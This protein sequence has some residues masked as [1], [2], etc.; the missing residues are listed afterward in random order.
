MSTARP[1]TDE[2]L[3]KMRDAVYPA[4]SEKTIQTDEAWEQVKGKWRADAE[5]LRE[6]YDKLKR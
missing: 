1:V 2:E 5:W 6:Q 3:R 4:T